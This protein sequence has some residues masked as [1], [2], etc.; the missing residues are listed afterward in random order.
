MKYL[1]LMTS[2]PGAWEALSTDEQ[3]SVIVQHEKFTNDLEADGHYVCS[4]Q[5]GPAADART[6][7]RD[8][9]G[10]LSEHSGTFA[11]TPEVVGGLYVI[12]AGSMDD[13]MQWA[14]RSRFI[15]GSNEVRPLVE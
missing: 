3:Q 11:K 12:E 8:G 2:A 14:R 9:E 7:R 5:L 4:Y 6:I 15:A 1:I 10:N 13:A